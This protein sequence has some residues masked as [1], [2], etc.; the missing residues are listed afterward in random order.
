M[1]GCNFEPWGCDWSSGAFTELK[2]LIERQ[3][4]EGDRRDKALNRI[5]IL[6]PAKPWPDEQEEEKAWTDLVRSSPSLDVY[7]KS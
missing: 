1:L 2:R 6:D 7:E 4:P 5:A 3:V